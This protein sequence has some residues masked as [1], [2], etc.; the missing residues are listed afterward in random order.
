MREL[1]GSASRSASVGA[2]EFATKIGTDIRTPLRWRPTGALADGRPEWRR[3]PSGEIPSGEEIHRLPSKQ[4]LHSTQNVRERSPLLDS[5]LSNAN[6]TTSGPARHEAGRGKEV[7]GG[8]ATPL[9]D[10]RESLGL[11]VV[12]LGMPHALAL[13]ED[14]GWPYVMPIVKAA[15][16]GI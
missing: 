9:L 13:D 7:P 4:S 3:G 14:T 5:T 1:Y 2:S 16:R 6:T 12:T 15:G 8:T 10:P 11:L